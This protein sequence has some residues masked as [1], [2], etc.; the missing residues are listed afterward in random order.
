MNGLKPR[1]EKSLERTESS[2]DPPRETD[3][4]SVD[5]SAWQFSPV[6]LGTIR[7]GKT[8]S[9][10]LP[11]QSHLTHYQVCFAK[12]KVLAALKSRLF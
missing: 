3:V 5:R 9:F 10:I 11:K 12:I 6:V 8:I 4:P 2:E 1:L 7:I